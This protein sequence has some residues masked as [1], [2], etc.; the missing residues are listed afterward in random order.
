MEEPTKTLREQLGLGGRGW[1]LPWISVVTYGLFSYVGFRLSK[2]FRFGPPGDD[3]PWY[4]LRH[5]FVAGASLA[6][7]MAVCLLIALFLRKRYP[8][9]ANV[10]MWLSLLWSGGSAWKAAVIGLG[11]RD[12]LNPALATTRWPSFDAYFGDPVIWA[13]QVG[14]WAAVLAFGFRGPRQPSPSMRMQRGTLGSR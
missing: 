5:D 14:V 1:W 4:F 9:N 2:D 7:G 12:L 6:V 11:S 3:R 13:G 10:L 8:A